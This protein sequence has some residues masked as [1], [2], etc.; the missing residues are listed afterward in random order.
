MFADTTAGAHAS[1]NIY[2]LL[3]SAKINKIQP[4][5]YLKHVLK[6]LP[7]VTDANEIE[8]LMPHKIDMSTCGD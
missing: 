2:S 3:V 8:S 5:K 1:A 7:N 6:T 4:Y